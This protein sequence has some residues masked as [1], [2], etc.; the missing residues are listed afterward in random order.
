MLQQPAAFDGALGRLR[1]ALS[2]VSPASALGLPLSGS[3]WGAMQMHTSG[4]K[5]AF[6]MTYVISPTAFHHCSADTNMWW[7]L[8]F[9]S[10]LIKL[11]VSIQI[12][13]R[14]LFCQDQ[15]TDSHVDWVREITSIWKRSSSSSSVFGR[16]LLHNFWGLIFGASS[17]FSF[18]MRTST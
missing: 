16:G 3:H 4:T 12:E 17:S 1:S 8:Y 14:S 9:R 2:S 15:L 18:S 13:W 11:P 10:H 5:K 6:P 7:L